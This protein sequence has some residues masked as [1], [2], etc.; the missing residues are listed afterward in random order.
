M[1]SPYQKSSSLPGRILARFF[2]VLLGFL[3]GA[4][5]FTPWNKIWA[6]AL[7]SLD[8][9][10]PSVGLKWDAIDRDGPFGFRVRG[11]RISVAN[12][13]GSLRFQQA[14]VNVGFSPVAHVRLDTGGPQCELNL[15]QSGAFEFEGDVN[16]TTLLGGADVRGVLRVAGNLFLPAGAVL[17]KN[18]WIDV[19]SQQLLLPDGK[20]VE[21]LAFTAEIHGRDMTVRDFSMGKPLAYKAAGTGVLHRGNLF[22]TRFD[23]KGEMTIGQRTF[24]YEMQ[25]SLADAVW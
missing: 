17:P 4:A 18:G 1:A 3:I 25:G 14:Y 22:R 23:L 2:L 8:E 12:T 15:F 6:S 20:S 24:P 10:L 13:P 19:R 7:A 5:L 11:L 9:R 21:D 16:L